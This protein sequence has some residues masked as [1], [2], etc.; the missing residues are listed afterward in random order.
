MPKQATF[1][2]SHGTIVADLF[3][4]DAPETVANFE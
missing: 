3:E 2:T 4:K 1:E